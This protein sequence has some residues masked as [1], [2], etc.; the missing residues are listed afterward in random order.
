MDRAAAGDRDARR[1]LFERYRAAAYQVALRI[2]GRNEDALD[3]VQDSFIKAFERLA[4]FQRQAGFKTWLLRIVTNRALDLLRARRVRLAIPLEGDDD[5][6]A[7]APVADQDAGPPDEPLERAELAERLAR[8]MES[9]PADQRAAFALHASGDM[10]YGQIAEVLGIPVG[11]V[12]SRLYHARRRLQA[13]LADLAPS[14][15]ARETE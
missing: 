4:G 1:V 9:L 8:A 15:A 6:G 2:T 11:T 14:G 10:T 12:M 7:L 13:V 5:A 3:A